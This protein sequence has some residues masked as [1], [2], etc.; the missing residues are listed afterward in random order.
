MNISTTSGVPLVIVPVL[1]KHIVVTFANSSMTTPPFIRTPFL[2]AFPTLA[3]TAVGV[4]KTNA[5]GQA[6]TKIDI[7]RIMSFVNIAVT[8]HMKSIVGRKNSANLS[9]VFWTLPLFSWAFFT[10]FIIWPR[11]VS[12]PI[13]SV[14]ISITPFSFKVP[15]NT[16]SW[17]LLSTGMDS[18]VMAASFIVAWPLLIIPST[19]IFSPAITWII[20]P[21]LTSRIDTSSNLS[22]IFFLHLWGTSF[23]RERTAFC[24]F[25]IVKSSRNSPKI[26]I[27]ETIEPDKY[28]PTYVV[29]IR[30]KTTKSPAVTFLFL[31]VASKVDLITTNP[32][33]TRGIIS[34]GNGS[35]I[36]IKKWNIIASIFN[37]N[38]VIGRIYILFFVINRFIFYT[39]F[40]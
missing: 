33:I 1:S 39:P 35:E 11:I 9:A 32:P 34:N 6:I 7:T 8:K 26:I 21:G 38:K 29:P 24:V 23:I 37:T 30:A 5:H 14:S 19:G 18:P 3:I 36:F 13:F 31:I 16:L 28:S 2:A 22:P 10:V 27:N 40:L 25:F 15:T 12:F 4:A 20:S 17:T